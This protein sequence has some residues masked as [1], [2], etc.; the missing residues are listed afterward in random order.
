MLNLRGWV[1]ESGSFRYI[2]DLGEMNKRLN[3]KKVKSYGHRYSQYHLRLI[4]FIAVC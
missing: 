4:T 1:T 2:V 3:N